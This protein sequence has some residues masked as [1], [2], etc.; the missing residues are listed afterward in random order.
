MTAPLVRQGRG[1]VPPAAAP[2]EPDLTRTAERL[3]QQKERD[4]RPFRM[5]TRIFPR[6]SSPGKS[7]PLLE[8]GLSSSPTAPVPVVS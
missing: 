3:G 6:L 4:A 5:A 2:F 8:N 1:W 7:P